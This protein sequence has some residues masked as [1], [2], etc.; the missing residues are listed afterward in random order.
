MTTFTFTLSGYRQSALEDENNMT[1]AHP[2]D[3]FSK[4]P[5]GL[6]GSVGTA[7]RRKGGRPIV[8]RNPG[9]RN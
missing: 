8:L 3:I 2:V 7:G 1:N 5:N 6:E 4:A 9:L